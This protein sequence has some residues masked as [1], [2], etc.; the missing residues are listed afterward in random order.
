[1]TASEGSGSGRV[2]LPDLAPDETLVATLRHGLTELNRDQRVGGHTDAPLI[3][4]GRDQAREA[5]A[6]LDHVTFD[7]VIS[8]PLRRAVETAT[9]VTGIEQDDLVIDDTTVERSFGLM[10]GLRPAEVRARFPEVRYMHIGGVGYS[11]N[12]PEGES[13]EALHERAHGFV[14]R[15]LQSY[16]GRRVLVVGHQNFLQQLHAVLRGEGPYDALV[17]DILNLELHQFVVGPDGRA[18]RTLESVPLCAT[19]ADYPSF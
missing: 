14:D 13:F 7:V 19:A 10:E 6:R 15:T 1:V 17:H 12:P 5:C 11:I 9:I 3:E 2:E 18:V 8:S 4:A 16:G